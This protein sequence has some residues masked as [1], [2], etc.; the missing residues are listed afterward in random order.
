MYIF[1]QWVIDFGIDKME[2]YMK[3]FGLGDKTGVEL[4]GEEKGTRPSREQIAKENREPNEKD[5]LSAAIGQSYNSYTPLQLAK[6]IAII[7]NGGKQIHPTIIKSII[8]PNGTR[9]SKE[10]IRNATKDILPEIPNIPEKQFDKQHIKAILEGMRAVTGERGGTAYSV[11]KNFNVE[12][13]GKTGSAEVSETRTD[14][15]FVGFAPFDDP[16]IG[17]VTVI[18]NGVVGFHTSEVVLKI[19]QEYFGMNVIHVKE[20]PQDV[21][22]GEYIL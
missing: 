4:V 7:A 8:K 18:E 2:E 17:I 12:V 9:L 11:F 20:N 5:I 21:P 6:Y 3:Y 10:E 15:L 14:G 19:M 16:E 22:E 1:I 13:G